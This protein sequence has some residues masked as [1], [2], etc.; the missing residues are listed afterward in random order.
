MN[1]TEPHTTPL[2]LADRGFPPRNA[3]DL[4]ASCGKYDFANGCSERLVP[5]NEQHGC[6]IH[7]L[8]GKPVVLRLIYLL[9]WPQSVVPSGWSEPDP[10]VTYPR[11]GT[12]REYFSYHLY[13]LYIL[14]RLLILFYLQY[15]H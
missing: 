8:H 3:E 4:A 11:E 9:N 13:P 7:G 1:K 14:N 5:T 2:Q 6:R 12:P 10:E 15:S